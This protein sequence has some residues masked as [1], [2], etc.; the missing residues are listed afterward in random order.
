MNRERAEIEGA[1]AGRTLCDELRQVA[2]TSGD[3]DAYS[4]EAG[5]GDGWRSLTW[6]QVRQRV[7][8][9]AAG[10]AA[11]GLA[12]GER[13]ALMLP[14]RSE[15][16]LADLGAV[17]AGGLGVTLYPTLAPEQIAY[18]AANCDARIAVLDGP[19]ELARWRPVLDQLPRL[20]R[21][22]VRD[23][24]ACPAGEPFLSW[25]DFA[26]LGAGQRLD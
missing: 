22:I 9:M 17:H 20:R 15:H 7:L 21:V 12:P 25:S 3:A 26:A 8:E 18:V 5:T 16:V 1:I 2:E 13:V 11:P 23:A 14:N 10:F 19:A 4:D 6:S 24:G